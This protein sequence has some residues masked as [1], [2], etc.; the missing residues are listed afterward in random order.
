VLAKI[1]L[2][3]GEFMNKK[4]L[5][6]WAGYISLIGEENF[7]TDGIDVSTKFGIDKLTPK[8][9]ISLL[10]SQSILPLPFPKTQRHAV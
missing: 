8:A 1:K 5:A 4:Q 7:H 3:K 2:A 10:Q 6:V 9:R